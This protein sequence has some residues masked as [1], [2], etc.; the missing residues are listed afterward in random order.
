MIPVHVSSSY[1]NGKRYTTSIRK[2]RNLKTLIIR[3]SGISMADKGD[4][5]GMC[6]ANRVT[7]LVLK[8][9]ILNSGVLYDIIRDYKW[10]RVCLHVKN[11]FTPNH[12]NSLIFARNVQ[13]LEIYCDKD[14]SS[15]FPFSLLKGLIKGNWV[16]LKIVG[17]NPLDSDSVVFNQWSS[18]YDS[19]SKPRMKT[20]I[21]DKAVVGRKIPVLLSKCGWNTL[22][23]GEKVSKIDTLLIK[24]VK[25]LNIKDDSEFF[26]RVG[27]LSSHEQTSFYKELDELLDEKKKS[28]D[29]RSCFMYDLIASSLPPKIKLKYGQAYNTLLSK[30]ENTPACS[31]ELSKTVDQFTFLSQLP[32]NTNTTRFVDIPEMENQLNGHVYGLHKEKR[33]I[34]SHYIRSN[35]Q[36][37]S[38]KTFGVLLV[39]PPGVGKTHLASS[40]E[41]S[42]GRPLI[43]VCL[44]G[45][46][47]TN[48]LKGHSFTYIGSKPGIIAQ[49]Y[50]RCGTESPIFLLDELDKADRSIQLCLMHLLDP[51][52]NSEWIDNFLPSCPIDLSSCFFILTANDTSC[53]DKILLNRLTVIQVQDY[54]FDERVEITKQYIWGDELREVG[55]GA[56]NYV[57]TEECL[58]I[59]VQRSL[60]DHGVRYIIR[61]IR[62][63]IDSLLLIK[64]PKLPMIISETRIR[65][66]L[67]SKA[68]DNVAKYMYT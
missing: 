68:G 47:D 38:S 23:N 51:S 36:K 54:S 18:M 41:K 50:S 26:E 61:D 45:M 57:L 63:I 16:T 8:L 27:M 9:S 48:L 5:L 58:K 44:D 42:T 53:I 7:K 40:V 64:S 15:N 10:K 21:L 17:V 22:I 31:S 1:N 39:G 49:E 66:C 33:K 37:S 62:D 19:V 28:G 25:E 3:G 4:I 20:F 34:V 14:V 67:Q 46:K 2:E 52:R 43:K 65:R 11:L 35:L 56:D 13:R 30:I 6:E 24:R 32:M 29:S 60:N 12:V 59:I 55:M